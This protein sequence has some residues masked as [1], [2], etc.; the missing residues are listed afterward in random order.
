MPRIRISTDS[1]NRD[2]SGA[3]TDI[4][5]LL[6]IFFIISAVFV[7]DQGILLKL[8]SPDAQPR[9]L[10]PDEVV[11]IVIESPGNYVVDSVGAT[12][13]EMRSILSSKIGLLEEPIV[14]V[15]VGAGIQ[16]QEVLIVLEEARSVG[17]SGF[18]IKT[19]LESPLGLQ[20]E[21]D[22]AR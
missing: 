8:P 17:Y 18:S 10:T 12:A 4:S 14:V 21:T 1:P 15:T 19:E 20:I 5:F 9:T 16:Y 2:F 7:T 6:I 22:A 11:S 13:E 3:M